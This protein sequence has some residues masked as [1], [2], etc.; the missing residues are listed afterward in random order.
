MLTSCSP[1]RYKP[2]GAVLV[3]DK[4][5]DGVVYVYDAP[6]GRVGAIGYHGKATKPDF[7]H[8]FRDAAAREAFVRRY[9]EGRQ[10][11]AQLQ[12]ETKAKARVPSKLQVG[13]VLVSSW[14][15][16]QTNVDWYQVTAVLGAHTVEIR[17]IG[18]TR[19]EATGHDQGK[20]VPLIDQF[21]G[22]AT[23][24][25]VTWGDGVKVRSFARATLWDG[26]PRFWSS[27]H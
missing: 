13:H 3:T 26:R 9:F 4:A 14:G 7:H 10:A 12:A 17:K 25:R 1:Y 18:A 8:T 24:H 20:C 27:Y 5:S 19:V 6:N 22:E 15:Y 16:E 21:I 11:R 2:Q 23:R